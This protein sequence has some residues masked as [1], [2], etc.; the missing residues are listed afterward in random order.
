MDQRPQMTRKILILNPVGSGLAHYTRSLEWVIEAVGAGVSVLAIDEPSASGRSRF[1]WLYEYCRLLLRARRSGKGA[2]MI[3]TWPVVGYWDFLIA[4]VLLGKD[5][6]RIVL[7]DPQPL[8]RAKGYGLIAR[9]TASLAAVQAKPLVHSD[10]AANVVRTQ[11]FDVHIESLPHPMLQPRAPT[12]RAAQPVIR[13]LGQYKADRDVDSL[14]RLAVDGNSDWRY[15][16]VGR[17]WSDIPGWHVSDRFVTE[18][19]FDTLISESS[20]I[21]I[22]YVRFFQSGVAIRSLE[23]GTPVVGPRASSL[24]NLLGDESG[25]LVEGGSWFPTVKAAVQADTLEVEMVA[26][27]V[28]LDVLDRWRA[29]LTGITKDPFE[30]TR[31]R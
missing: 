19:E 17:G 30:Q 14:R 24:S 8:V 15:E 1:R 4:R 29:W 25:W 9:R 21:L 6:A 27:A 11:T 18:N 12:R 10:L 22:P 2:E 26:K 23:M 20:V 31:I 13:V 3:I 16:I 28:Y 7:H 5:S